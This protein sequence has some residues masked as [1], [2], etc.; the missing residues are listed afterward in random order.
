M[1]ARGKSY[2]IANPAAKPQHTISI[3][4]LIKI[5]PISPPHLPHSRFP[6]PDSRLPT[7][8]SRL[9]TPDSLLPTPSKK[10]CYKNFQTML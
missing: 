9:P 8:D 1:H 10:I 6:I 3:T 4:N 2:A 7:P 5:F